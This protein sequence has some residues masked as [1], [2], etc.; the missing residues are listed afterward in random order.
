MEANVQFFCKEPYILR[1]H[2]PAQRNEMILRSERKRDE[3]TV[4]KERDREQGV[5]N[6]KKKQWE[7]Y[8][9]WD[10]T[11][12]KEKNLELFF[13]QFYSNFPVSH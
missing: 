7:R 1:P 11:P 2:F 9:V 13:P 6:E 5:S 10:Q 3:S 4:E 12:Q 8:L